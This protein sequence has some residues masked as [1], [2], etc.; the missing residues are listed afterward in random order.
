MQSSGASAS[1]SLCSCS[2]K[3]YDQTRMS[4]Q[5]KK[6][7]RTPPSAGHS[8]ALSQ[9]SLNQTPSTHEETVTVACTMPQSALDDS[10]A[11]PLDFDR[12]YREQR[13]RVFSAV[14]HVLGPTDEIE[15]VTQQA[16]LEI[17]RSLPRFEG[18]SR[19]STFVYRIAVNVALQHIRRKKRWRWL[20]LGATG[21]EASRVPSG[22][23]QESRLVDRG[24]LEVVYDAVDKLSEKKRAVWT[25]HE[26]EG[27]EPKAIADVLEVP[28]NTVRSR[29]IAARKDV[30]ARL[31]ARG[32]VE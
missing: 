10:E 4:E 19:V 17:Y 20:S 27:L 9:P 21:D 32:V 5:P 2:N 15:D 23:S 3:R 1:E 31:R 18:R 16:F 12:V 26:L 25:L 28:V 24:A 30:M 8:G 13:Q 29:L 11:K 14:R 6:S 22:T 7:D